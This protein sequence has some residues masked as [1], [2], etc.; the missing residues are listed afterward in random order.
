MAAVYC[1]TNC[2][3]FK[4]VVVVGGRVGGGVTLDLE[5][6]NGYGVLCSGRRALTVVCSDHI[7]W[8]GPDSIL[9]Q[10]IQ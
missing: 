3:L 5:V 6:T 9:S 4:V 8:R 10:Q 7:H 2:W 1:K